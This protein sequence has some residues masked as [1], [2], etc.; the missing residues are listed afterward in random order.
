MSAITDFSKH[1]MLS[2]LLT[3]T[4]NLTTLKHRAVPLHNGVLINPAVYLGADAQVFNL[5]VYGSNPPAVTNT[6]VIQWTAINNWPTITEIAILNAG[7]QDVIARAILPSP[8]TMTAGS[9]FTVPINSW[10][11]ALV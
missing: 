7:S 6:E 5:H 11:I 10:E 3:T 9:I 2:A 8:Y 4:R 1:L